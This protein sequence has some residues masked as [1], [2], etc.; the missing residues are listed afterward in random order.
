VHPNGIQYLQLPNSK[1]LTADINRWFPISRAIIAE[2]VGSEVPYWQ[3]PIR[4]TTA[5][6][7]ATGGGGR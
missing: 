2:V 7:I 4:I 1:L 3:M 6:T 5:V